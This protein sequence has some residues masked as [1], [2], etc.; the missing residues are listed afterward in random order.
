MGTLKSQHKEHVNKMKKIKLIIF[1]ILGVLVISS[2]LLFQKVY[3][4]ITTPNTST[5]DNYSLYIGSNDGF[6]TIKNKLYSD[7]IIINKKSFEWWANEVEY[8]LHI[9]SGY[10][11]IKNGLSNQELL[12]LLRS[13]NQTPVRFTFNNMRTTEQ[14]A[15][16]IAEQIEVDSLSILN[17]IKEDTTLKEMGFNNENVA[18]LFIPNTYE[19]YWDISAT[20]LL[21]KM[22]N[23]YKKFWNE[24]RKKKADSLN[25]TPIEV[26]ILASIIDKETSKVSEMPCIAGVYINRLKNNWLLQ[27]DPT[28]IFA[29]GDFEIKRVLNTHKEIESPYNTYKYIGLPPGPICI[30]SIAAIDA[31]LNAEEHKYFYFCAKDDLSGSHVFAKSLK[32]HNINAEKYRKALNKMKIWK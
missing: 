19:V 30:P 31:V 28:L 10:Y 3:K 27:A 20:E 6:E 18:S 32:E 23:E 11:I 15:A 8:P 13:G 7:K 24:D 9:K 29:H 14:V 12:N 1:C 25:M 4:A 21:K 22:T 26:S 16:R 17:A 5:K 2:V